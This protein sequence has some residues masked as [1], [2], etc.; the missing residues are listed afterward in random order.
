MIALQKGLATAAEHADG[1]HSE[2]VKLLMN[3]RCNV[4]ASLAVGMLRE[5]MPEA[6]LVSL[7]NLRELIAE[8]PSES[9][10]I[11]ERLEMLGRTLGYLA[12]GDTW[13]LEFGDAQARRCLEFVGDGNRVDS[14]NLHCAWGSAS[15]A[16][17]DS[18]FLSPG[19]AEALLTDTLWGEKLVQALLTLGMPLSPKFYMCVDDYMFENAGAALDDIKAM[20]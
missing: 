16:G 9:F 8:L 11:P 6:H 5:S 18:D 4:E 7:C 14:V 3:S 2:L 19:M 10:L 1:E 15:L 12:E 13:H 20:F 17:V